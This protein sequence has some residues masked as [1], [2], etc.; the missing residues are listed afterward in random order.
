MTRVTIRTGCLSVAGL[1]A[2]L[3]LL[4]VPANTTH[5]AKGL[6]TMRTAVGPLLCVDRAVSLQVARRDETFPAQRAAIASLPGV[7]EQVDPQVVGLGKAFPT[8]AAGVGFLL[9][10]DLLVQLQGR[11]AGEDLLTNYTHCRLF[12][13]RSATPGWH[14]AGCAGRSC[15][16]SGWRRRRRGDEGSV[17]TSR[18]EGG[19]KSSHFVGS[20]CE[21]HGRRT[22]PLSLCENRG[23][24][25][26]SV[27]AR[28]TQLCN[29]IGCAKVAGPLLHPGQV[30]AY[31]V[32]V[33]RTG[34]IHLHRDCQVRRVQFLI[35]SFIRLDLRL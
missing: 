25:V 35:C 18:V 33:V 26:L 7:D 8:V 3:R 10:V 15:R 16:Y 5:L 29:C 28:Q 1:Q 24:R 27:C 13:G 30:Q 4:P 34:F 17:N 2:T 20:T 23:Q 12:S 21:K 31:N 11:R 14:L 9:C 32:E 19:G 6:S 22:V